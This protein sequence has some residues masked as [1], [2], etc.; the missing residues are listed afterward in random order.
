[1]SSS[2]NYNLASEPDLKPSASRRVWLYFI[3]LGA[4]LYIT[5][6]GLDVFYRFTLSY[7]KEIK[8]GAVSTHEAMDKKAMSE[9]YLSGKRGLFPDKSFVP[10][11]IAMA[12]LLQ[13]FRSSRTRVLP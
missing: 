10:I 4:L 5:I 11:D 9:A 6:Y 12:K 7:E 2:H 3:I 13:E 1:M 8:I